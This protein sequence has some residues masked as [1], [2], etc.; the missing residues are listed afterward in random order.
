MEALNFIL[1]QGNCQHDYIAL[2]HI[3]DV[4]RIK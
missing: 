2:K 1:S 3:Q 4:K